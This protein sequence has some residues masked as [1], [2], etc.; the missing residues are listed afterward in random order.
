VHVTRAAEVHARDS[1]RIFHYGRTRAAVATLLMLALVVVL[2]TL[3]WT[4]HAWPLTVTAVVWLA[5]LALM[6]RL[7]TARFRPSNWLVRITDEGLWVQFRSYLNY[8]FPADD[9]TVVF[10]SFGEIRSARQVRERS[11][12]RDRDARVSAS[13]T[14]QRRRLI[15]LELAGDTTALAAALAAEAARKGPREKHWYG[16][17]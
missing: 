6:E 11:L 10:L 17:S 7:V 3:G 2:A 5:I 8:H 4:K 12:V 14:V 1:D 15:E 9:L 13:T 16:S